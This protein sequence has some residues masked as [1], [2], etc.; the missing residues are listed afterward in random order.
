M[1][2]ALK[3]LCNSRG[4][5]LMVCYNNITCAD[6]VIEEL[7]ASDGIIPFNADSLQQMNVTGN[8]VV[9]GHGV[10]AD[11]ERH[12]LFG[13]AQSRA[14]I[15]VLREPLSLLVSMWKHTSRAEVE[16]GVSPY[17]NWSL[18]QWIEA[19]LAEN[20]VDYYVRFFL[21]LD[22][23]VPGFSCHA[24]PPHDAHPP[25]AGTQT[26][27]HACFV[28]SPNW[29]D[30]LRAT[31]LD[32]NVLVLIQED[33]DTSLNR[34]TSFLQLDPAEHNLIEGVLQHIE[35]KAPDVEVVLSEAN[36]VRLQSV[37]EPLQFLY[38][39]VS[40]LA[41][42]ASFREVGPRWTVVSNT[43]AGVVLKW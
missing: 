24:L 25:L 30:R 41:E 42:P 31:V 33:W 1:R 8:Q 26:S 22:K 37:V 15:A 11:F 38:M 32:P 5:N 20:F 4:Q 6:P 3:A 9:Y 34:L 36:L 35:N 43:S 2:E 16:H 17:H 13:N 29:K 21:D 18:N 10:Q 27:G 7:A 28:S 19:G 12:W 40:K 23:E 14:R 39:E